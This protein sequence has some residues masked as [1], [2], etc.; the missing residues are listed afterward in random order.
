MMRQTIFA[1]VLRVSRFKTMR[2]LHKNYFF[3][4]VF[5]FSLI[6][7]V[8]LI[9]AYAAPLTH[10]ISKAQHGPILISKAQ[11]LDTNKN[12]ISDITEQTRVKDNVYCEPIRNGEY[13]RVT[14]EQV[15]N[16][17]CDN[18]IYARPINPNK[19]AEIE[20]YP[21]YTD[22]K[23]NQ[24]EFPP[25]GVF[26]TIN[27]EGYY[28]ILLT[29]LMAPT[30][31]FDLKITGSDSSGPTQGVGIDY[32]F[33]ATFTLLYSF[34]TMNYGNYPFGGLIL[35][36]STLYGMTEAGGPYGDGIIFSIST[37]GG[38]FTD[39]H[40]FSGST[41][42]GNSPM[43][44]LTLSGSTLYGMTRY[45]GTKSDGIIFSISTS[46]GT[47][48]DLHNFTGSKTDG[49]YPYGSLTLSGSTLYGMTNVGGTSSSGIIFSISTSGGALTDLHNFTGST[50]DGANPEGSLTLSGSTLY[51][52][53]TWGGAYGDGI[54]F[55]IS[56]SGSSFKDLH[57]FSGS[58][59]DGQAPYDSLT[60]TGSTLYGMTNQGGAY[61][62]GI[63][64]SITTSGGSFTDLH[65]FSGSTTDGKNPEGSLTLSGSTLYGTAYQGGAYYNLYGIV[66]SISTSGSSFTDLHDFSANP[67][68]GA[69]PGSGFLIL[70]GS[71]LY[72]MTSSGGHANEGMIFSIP[73]SG[74][75]IPGNTLYG[76]TYAGGTANEGTIFSIVTSGLTQPS[77]TDMHDFS[78]YVNGA[79]PYGD[80][81]VSGSTMYGMLPTGGPYND[82]LIFSIS[83]S[84]GSFTD[85]HDFSGGEFDGA[86]PQG[87]LVLSGS[88]L[89]GMTSSGGTLGWGTIFSISTSGGPLT[90]M[91]D[92]AGYYNFDGADPVGSLII[93]GSTL[94]GMTNEGGA[95]SGQD[96]NGGEIFS[97]PINGGGETRL[98]G[99][100][101]GAGDGAFPYG[102]LTISGGT[103]YGMTE[104]YGAY[105]DGI[106]FSIST[107]GGALTDLHDFSESS[108]DGG[109]PY[110]TSLTLSGG[111]L[112]GMTQYGGASGYGIIFSIS[113]SGG[114]LTDLHDFTA[115]AGDGEWPQGSL[116]LSGSTLYG[117]TQYGGASG[118]GIIFSISTS[119]GALTVLHTFTGSATDGEGPWGDL[120]LSGGT[121]YGMTQNGGS[122]GE[123]A[124]FSYGVPAS[125]PS[126]S[127]GL[128]FGT[129]F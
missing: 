111:T 60:L 89:Y 70:S 18:S 19:P 128:Y 107:G 90:I 116:T 25:I 66:F 123:G 91:W 53:T 23:G 119:G 76:M 67:T 42:D 129:D 50:T 51:G 120:A 56:T 92:F 33:D 46:G 34:G 71:T 100:C 124:I 113:T 32:I 86:L 16:R 48:T 88:T 17:N 52:M 41:T 7:F 102:S 95:F 82:G 127:N 38:S 125:L 73:I 40:D 75:A 105:S 59:T 99:F 24:I 96:C 103:L 104:R 37:S 122:A 77:L 87:S 118:Y 4:L 55:S 98:H 72:G 13:V 49:K 110:Y 58:T 47:L 9:K 108:T 78:G 6:L 85:L 45:G 22:Q 112:Y 109:W 35:S 84:G 20:V 93:S 11:H 27:S 26:P 101:G 15:L 2:N 79:T 30:D 126:S 64:F 117:M 115:G 83:T 74:G 69:Y 5:C 36:G 81:A 62:D 10:A 54:V 121:F 43:G 8:M 44:S 12:L 63:I 65:D 80:L 114:A 61:S 21:V 14:F 97:I 39:L 1:P 29:Q 28:K 3:V 106:I 57:D 68:D 31:T 94:Y